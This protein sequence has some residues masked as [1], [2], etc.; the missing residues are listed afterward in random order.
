MAASVQISE[1]GPR[2]L[3]AVQ[4][5]EGLGEAAPIQPC[6]SS[7][8]ALSFSKGGSKWVELGW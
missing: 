4:P 3:F 7:S 2:T 1:E 6:P 8:L 5:E